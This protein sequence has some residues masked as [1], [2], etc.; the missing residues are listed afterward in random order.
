MKF[1]SGLIKMWSGSDMRM[2]FSGMVALVIHWA[3]A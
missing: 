2:Y 1:G 3:K